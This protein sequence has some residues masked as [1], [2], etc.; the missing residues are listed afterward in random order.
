MV[1]TLG[2]AWIRKTAEGEEILFA[3]DSRLSDSELIWDDCPKL[4]VLPRLGTVAGFSGSTLQAYPLLLQIFSSIGSYRPAAD[5]T[6]EFFHMLGHLERVAN[7]MMQRITLDPALVRIRGGN[8]Q[9]F[10]TSGDTLVIGGYSR[11]TGKMVI[12]LLGYEPD[13][14]RWRFHSVRPS[15]SFGTAR[16]IAVYGDRRSVSRYRFLLK[17]SLIARGTHASSVAFDLEP[18]EV[19]CG[20]LSMRDSTAEKLPMDRRPASIGGA[21]QVIRVLAGAHATSL[22]VR[23]ES[24]SSENVFLQGRMTLAYE[25]LDVPLLVFDPPGVQLHAPGK[26]PAVTNPPSPVESLEPD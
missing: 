12:R 1:M 17:K 15:T 22:A 14:N 8:T 11:L 25:N 26:W 7:A 9:E 10:A 3:S 4:L 6:M 24:D 5:G 13:R 21:P 18:L 16:T 2:V 23:W 20:L 19:L